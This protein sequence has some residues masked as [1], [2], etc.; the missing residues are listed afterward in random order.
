MSNIPVNGA[1]DKLKFAVV[2]NHHGHIYAMM[3]GLLQTGKAECLGYYAEEE[4]LKKQMQRAFPN[5]PLARS[6][7]EL[8]GH[9]QIQLICTAAKNSER[10]DLAIKAMRAGKHFFVDKPGVTSLEQLEQLSKVQQ[11]TG[12]SWFLWFC[13]RLNDPSA[14]KAV[15]MVREGAIGKLV[16]FVGLEPHKLNRE[17][18]PDWMFS[19]NYYGGILND[20][21]LH[22]LDLFLLLD[23]Q[24]VEIKSA[25]TANF[26]C[27]DLPEFE[28]FGEVLLESK[29][30][31]SAYIRADWLGAQTMPS[32]GDVRHILTGTKGVIELRKTMDFA[33]DNNRFTGRQLLW[34]NHGNEP[35]RI[36]CPATG[37]GFFEEL[38]QD[39]REGRNRCIPHEHSFGVSRLALLAQKKAD[40]NKI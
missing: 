3:K 20:L 36:E 12:K 26:N 37:A 19:R 39:I 33:V 32:F 21:G 27:S 4:L 25:R 34:A 23:K 24:D 11:E 22:Q 9:P 16:N 15:E 28:D 31:V 40:M 6:A 30:D 8:I 13:E 2:G 7:D 17:Q 29:A 18:R 1:T 38:I 10:A 14:A 35:Q 5:V